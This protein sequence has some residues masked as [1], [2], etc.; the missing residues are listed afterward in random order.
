MRSDRKRRKLN[1][2]YS[3]CIVCQQDDRR[4]KVGCLRILLFRFFDFFSQIFLI[5]HPIFRDY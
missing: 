1:T 2:D 5:L 3:K 4:K